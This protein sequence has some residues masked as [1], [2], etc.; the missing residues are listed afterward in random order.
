[1]RIFNNVR[2]G[3]IVLSYVV[4][5]CVIGARAVA[6]SIKA[7]S[8]DDLISQQATTINRAKQVSTSSKT[9]Y[10]EKNTDERRDAMNYALDIDQDIYVVNSGDVFSVRIWKQG[11]ESSE[12]QAAVINGKIFLEMIGEID[13]AGLSLRQAVEKISKNYAERFKQFNVYVTLSYMRMY[14]VL[15]AGQVQ[16]PGYY[17]ATPMTRLMDIVNMAGGILP[18][19]SKRSATIADKD[20]KS[21]VFDLFKFGDSGDASQNPL[22]SEQNSVFIPVRFG[23][24]TVKGDAIKPGECEIVEG[25]NLYSLKDCFIDIAP[26]GHRGRILLKRPSA[27]AT[28]GEGRYT[29]VPL[30]WDGFNGETG[31]NTLLTDGDILEIGGPAESEFVIINGHVNSPGQYYFMKGMRVSDLL[32]SAGGM[33][34]VNMD[35][36]TIADTRLSARQASAASI[37]GVYKLLINRVDRQSGE[38]NTILIDLTSL[39]VLG[40][41]EKDI[42]LMPGDVLSVSANLD[43]VYVHGFVARPGFFPYDPSYTV[44][45][46]I[47]SAGGPTRDGDIGRSKLSRNVKTR[48]AELD[49]K[50]EPG[51]SIYVAADVKSSMKN[52]LSF[53]SNL[54]TF[55]LMIDRI[56]D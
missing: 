34:I 50:L 3:F 25:D 11:L 2:N 46:F 33:K 44:R 16:S 14:N 9:S 56:W 30:T 8:Y 35:Q 13:V 37:S 17:A 39:L 28:S 1:M 24:A 26:Q 38:I 42:E 48:T 12:Y 23:V 49:E 15:V 29:I 6:L 51:D 36:D 18:T 47:F 41:N 27:L 5:L 52:N 32:N 55:Y 19:G 31:R 40:D 20:G 7:D 53:V 4:C 22:I 45:D 43:V 21:T 10:S 54:I